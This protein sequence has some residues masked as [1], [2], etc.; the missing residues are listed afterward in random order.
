MIKGDIYRH[1]IDG[2]GT[3]D[4]PAAAFLFGHG[5]ALSTPDRIGQQPNHRRE[6]QYW[7]GT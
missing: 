2:I 4:K 3:G 5:E 6:L 1:Y 7:E